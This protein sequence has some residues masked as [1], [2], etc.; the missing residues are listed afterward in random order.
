M[1]PFLEYLVSINFMNLELTCFFTNTGRKKS[2]FGAGRQARVCFDF[3]MFFQLKLDALI[4]SKKGER[5]TNLPSDSELKMCE[6]DDFTRDDC[7]NYDVLIAVNE[8]LNDEIEALLE[9]KGFTHIYTNNNWKV[10][11]EQIRE[12]YFQWE[13]ERRGVSLEDDFIKVGKFKI[14]NYK[15]I[16]SNE[17]KTNLFTEFFDILL[18]GL[19]NDDT[20]CIEGPYEFEECKL[21][22]GDIVIDA[23]ANIGLFS[24]Y[25]ASRVGDNGKIY[26]FEPTSSTCEIIK[27]NIDEYD[28]GNLWKKR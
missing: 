26:A 27:N 25:A 3:M 18:P 17:Y 9:D 7:K 12:L 20:R 16:N 6:L 21:D 24:N 19:W 15:K 14:K 4:V 11:N 2:F 8:V 1:H 23:G 22:E 5:H 10:F 13:F 28:N